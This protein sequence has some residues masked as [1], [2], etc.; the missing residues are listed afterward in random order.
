MININDIKNGIKEEVT[1]LT[2]EKFGV[3]EEEVKVTFTSVGEL[4]VS[5]VPKVFVE[6]LSASYS[7]SQEG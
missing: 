7:I 5:I 4:S 1:K 3:K 2:C 6:S